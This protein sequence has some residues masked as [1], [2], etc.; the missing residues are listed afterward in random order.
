MLFIT[1][2]GTALGREG[3]PIS[4]L[5]I[6]VV[7]MLAACPY[8]LFS[9]S[10]WLS[11][12]A[13]LG[14]LLVSPVVREFIS[15]RHRPFVSDV[16][17]DER[18]TVTLRVMLFVFRSV[19][20]WLVGCCEAF[21]CGVICGVAAC[22]FSVPFSLFFFGSISYSAIP[23]G[24]L[25]SFVVTVV[26]SIAPLVLL[27]CNIPL[28]SGF[29]SFLGEA[30]FT[31]TDF[32]SSLHGAYI[33]ARYTSVYVLIGV[34][35]TVIL[36]FLLL[37]KSKTPVLCLC[38]CLYV[39]IFV[40]A[41]ISERVEYSSPSFVYSEGEC[42]MTRGESGLL[43]VD[44]G[45]GSVSAIRRSLSA[46]SLLRENYIDTFVFTHLSSNHEKLVH[47]LLTNY[48]VDTL[49]FPNYASEH[50]AILAS[51]GEE[52]A[53]RYGVDVRY[54]E[55]GELFCSDGVM[56]EVSEMEY[57]DRS[58]IPLYSV[59]LKVRGESV[60]WLSSSYF[61]GEGGSTVYDGSY[62]Y[63]ILGTYG[64]IQREL[65]PLRLL[66]ISASCYVLSDSD[67]L[68]PQLEGKIADRLLS[69]YT[70]KVWYLSEKIK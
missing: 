70:D 34:F 51:A 55:Y 19:R 37:C 15:H 47:F 42:V 2:M 1:Y 68:T 60:L 67:Q 24:I 40:C 46:S 20:E 25:L 44:M 22:V 18:Y 66:D 45:G 48:K 21:I 30:Y 59:S 10:F 62:D 23:C 11:V 7:I 43:A 26:L 61:D 5:C 12:S 4:S 27:L 63:V 32:F 65:V 56:V 31:I 50:M 3:D 6:A 64:P 29:A 49:Y 41:G 52:E 57:L 8:Y 28:V 54:F 53:E 35:L 38:A 17:R 36:L 58:R 39:S 33:N 16:L 14:I 69:P 13:T 9:A